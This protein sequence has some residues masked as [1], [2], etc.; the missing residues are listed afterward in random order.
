DL[1][2]GRTDLGVVAYTSVAPMIESG[3]LKL[4]GITNPTR[5]P[6]L[7]DLPTIAES[8]EG[9]SAVGWFGFVAPAGTP[10]QVVNRLNEEIN[11]ALQ[12]PEV[13]KTMGTVGLIPVTKSP[14]E[15]ADLLKSAN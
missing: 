6:A 13:Q 2:G 14:E 7:P 10:S 9:Y 12:M 3:R 8:V 4:L 15:F 11:E 5:D 1:T